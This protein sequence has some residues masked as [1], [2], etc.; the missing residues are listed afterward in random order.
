MKKLGLF[1]AIL[2]LGTLQV[3]AMA[4]SEALENT[5]LASKI[6]V[7]LTNSETDPA[8]VISKYIKAVGGKG[9]VTSI[10]FNQELTDYDFK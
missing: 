9:K 7:E 10:L 5:G 2:T 4:G 8:E 1:A 3:S 6:R